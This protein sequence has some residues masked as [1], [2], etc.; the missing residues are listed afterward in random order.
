M[1]TEEEEKRSSEVHRPLSRITDYERSIL[2]DFLVD[3]CK[4]G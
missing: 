2:S 3:T 1:T 4:T